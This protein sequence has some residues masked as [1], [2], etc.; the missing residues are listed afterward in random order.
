MR[1]AEKR[2]AS[3]IFLEADI[4][5]NASSCM[6]CTDIWGVWGFVADWRMLTWYPFRIF[7]QGTMYQAVGLSPIPF[8]RYRIPCSE[9]VLASLR[10]GSLPRIVR[11]GSLRRRDRALPVSF[12]AGR[13]LRGQTWLARRCHRFLCFAPVLFRARLLL[14]PA[15]EPGAHFLGDDVV[16]ETPLSRS[17]LLQK[18]AGCVLHRCLLFVA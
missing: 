15:V 8:G 1:N 7:C 12:G 13:L 6:S 9:R 2:E 17:V 16:Q 11:V 10:F 4:F 3:L 14:Q 18:T 5:R